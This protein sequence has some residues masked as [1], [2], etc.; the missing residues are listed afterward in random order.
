M[1]SVLDGFQRHILAILIYVVIIIFL[2]FVL[3]LLRKFCC[4]QS[5]EF[6]N[7]PENVFYNHD[8]NTQ[9]SRSPYILPQPGVLEVPYYPPS[10]CDNRPSYLGVPPTYTDASGLPTYDEAMKMTNSTKSLGTNQHIVA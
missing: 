2:A 4:R 5:N 9:L 1:V 6:G 7:D 3:D 8:V 10:P